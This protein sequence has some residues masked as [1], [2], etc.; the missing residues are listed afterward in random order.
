MSLHESR[1]EQARRDLVR[2]RD[3][4][5]RASK[6]I[7]DERAKAARYRQQAARTTSSGLRSSHE[8]QAEAAEKRALRA[9][10]D[11]ASIDADIARKERGLYD[12][13]AA[14]EK[15]RTATFERSLRE[16][17]QQRAT[18]PFAT[19]APLPAPATPAKEWDF[20]ISHASPDKEE[21][22]RAL[23]EG[24]TAAGAD[25]WYDEFE[26]RV[27]DSLRAKIDEGLSRSRY[28]IVV[29]T[30]AYLAGR[31]WT[32][33]ELAGLFAANKRILPIWHRV[34]RDEVAAYSPT[35]ADRLALTTATE[36]LD[37]IVA[38]L[39]EL[40]RPE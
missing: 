16:A 12:A 8:R 21:L 29:L 14:V 28:G 7:A 31:Q 38:S 13:Q 39:L 2:L 40:L 25:V 15:A 27:G 35:L 30:P 9:E 37:T 33:N 22:V 26:L 1:V 6:K 23:A 32:D 4:A 19:T 3:N 36:S 17:R 5:A 34:S 18:V 24:L 10:Q 20:F 11:R